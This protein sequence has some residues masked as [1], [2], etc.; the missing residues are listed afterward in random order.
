MKT[1]LK[2]ARRAASSALRSRDSI[3]SDLFDS[4]S[5]SNRTNKRSKAAGY[6][7]IELAFVVGIMGIMAAAAT[8]RFVDWNQNQKAISAV[9]SLSSLLTLARSEAMRTSRNQLVLFNVAAVS[10]VDAAGNDIEDIQGNPVPV[11]FN[12]DGAAGTGNCAIDNTRA[13]TALVGLDNLRL[14]WGVTYASSRAP[15]DGG[16]ADIADGLTFALITAPSTAV[17][18]L[19]FRADGVPVTFTANGSG[20]LVMGETGSGGGAIYVTNGERDFAVVLTPLGVTR[21]HVW[22]KG[23]GGWSQ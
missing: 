5:N 4:N 7:L 20:C 3:A 10:S 15:L 9:R 13:L 12:D 18:A 1:F 21:F 2:F 8:S 17:N 14:E 22:A 11:L 19:M 16:A 23:G 6:T